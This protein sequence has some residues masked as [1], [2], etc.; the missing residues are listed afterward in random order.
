M[1]SK[2]TNFLLSKSDKKS[3]S[4]MVI[5]NV[6]NFANG[7]FSTRNKPNS[8]YEIFD[9]NFQLKVINYFNY[10]SFVLSNVIMILIE[11]FL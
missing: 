7:I 1:Y 8:G 3:K 2:L 5:L 9:W 10:V 6:K 4:R 11:V